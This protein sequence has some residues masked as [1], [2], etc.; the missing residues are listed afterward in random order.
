MRPFSRRQR[1]S[2][3]VL[4]LLVIA[5]LTGLSVAFSGGAR[6]EV[7]LA[8]L[9]RDALR[10]EA[11]ARAGVEAALWE[12]A[13]DEDMEADHVQEAWGLFTGAG[14]PLELP[15]E[16]S[17]SG[18][19]WDETGKLN[20]NHLLAGPGEIDETWAGRVERLLDLLGFDPIAF[21]SLL[22]WLDSDDI[23]RM[24]GAESFHYQGLKVPYAC[25][26]GPL[27]SVRQA[28]LVRGFGPADAPGED[29]LRRLAEAATV[30]TNGR[31]NVNTAPLEVLESLD[32]DMDRSLAEAIA[33][34]R[35]D[36]PFQSVAEVMEVPGMDPEAFQRMEGLLAVTTS[37]FSV[38]MEGRWAEASCRM[39]AV[40]E[41]S[42]DGV[43]WIYW[44]VE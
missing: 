7:S 34:R 17:L 3:L 6:T 9:S 19:V 40:I 42:E 30:Y 39:E 13:A 12:I 22:D 2:V 27:F 21:E 32:P 36:R 44:R 25:G 20:L 23:R 38:R 41:R 24:D 26:N 18:G 16:A 31:V 10:A 28:A 5:T 11:L 43:R 33:E 1:G 37:V 15:E 29:A 35:A 8:A 14:L 4:A